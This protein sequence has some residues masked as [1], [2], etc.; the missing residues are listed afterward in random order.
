MALFRLRKFA[1]AEAELSKVAEKHAASAPA[2]FYRGRA[3]VG[4]RRLADAEKEFKRVVEIGGDDV[5]LAYRY[6]AG[7]YLEWHER[8]KALDALTQY[9]ALVPDSSET[10]QI[11]ELISKLKSSAHKK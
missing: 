7:I 8:A 6:L 5:A 3:F 1:H 2:H 4:L 11:L 9:R 10:P